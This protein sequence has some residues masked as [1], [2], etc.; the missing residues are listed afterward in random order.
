MKERTISKWSNGFWRKA[1][2]LVL[3]SEIRTQCDKTDKSLKHTRKT[4]KH[5]LYILEQMVGMGIAALTC[6]CG[7]SHCSCT[8]SGWTQRTTPTWPGPGLLPDVL[9][10][11]TSSS[12]VGRPVWPFP[13]SCWPKENHHCT[14]SPRW[15]QRL[16]SLC[17]LQ[18]Y[19]Y[20][21]LFLTFCHYLLCNP[22]CFIVIKLFV[23]LWHCS[24]YFK[25]SELVFFGT[26]HYFQYFKRF[27]KLL[28]IH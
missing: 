28:F 8:P 16:P 23:L 19:M 5:G 26:G 4:Q 25:H 27:L 14:A 3:I 24:G 10:R 17:L 6:A 20:I 12:R 11:S 22:E 21:F 15:R 1:D 7:L 18:H 9:S 2:G 13:S